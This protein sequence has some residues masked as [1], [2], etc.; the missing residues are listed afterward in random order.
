MGF[1]NRYIIGFITVLCL[2]CSLAVSATAVKLKP[3]QDVNKELDM[4]MQVVQVAGLVAPG[5]KVSPEQVIELFTHLES[6]LVDRK[7][8]EFVEG[9]A[10]AYDAK[11]AAKD[12]SVSVEIRCSATMR[13]AAATA[14]PA[15]ARLVRSASRSTSRA[16][17]SPG[18]SERSAARICSIVRA[19]AQRL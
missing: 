3:R 18:S 4:N 7:T 1:S 15:C 5:E 10:L 14:S 6:K 12:P 2:I 16:R 8:G 19:I 11:K 9:D 13:A 17:G